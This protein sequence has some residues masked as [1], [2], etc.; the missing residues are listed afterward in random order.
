ME[1]RNRAESSVAAAVTVAEVE[2]VVDPSMHRKLGRWPKQRFVGPFG[3][4]AGSY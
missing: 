3:A 1:H 2:C 4:C